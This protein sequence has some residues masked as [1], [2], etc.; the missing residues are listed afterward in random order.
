[1][2]HGFG[3]HPFGVHLSDSAIKDL[4]F[5]AQ[6]IFYISEFTYL[7]FKILIDFKFRENSVLLCWNKKMWFTNCLSIHIGILQPAAVQKT[8]YGI[9]TRTIILDIRLTWLLF[10]KYIM[11]WIP[12]I[13]INFIYRSFLFIYLLMLCCIKHPITFFI[14][15]SMFGNCPIV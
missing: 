4:N 15:I 3:V 6:N 14:K 2:F 10:V 13:N 12:K 1:M 7:S 11:F 8:L 9:C 5:Q